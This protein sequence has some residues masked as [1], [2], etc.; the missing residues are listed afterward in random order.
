LI[1]ISLK[2]TQPIFDDHAQES[3]VV[4]IFTG[5][6]V[7]VGS[8]VGVAVGVGS[9]VAVGSPSAGTTGVGVASGVGV[10]A[11]GLDFTSLTP[12][13]KTKIA[14]NKMNKLPATNLDSFICHYYILYIVNIYK[15]CG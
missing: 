15:Y 4:G 7:G 2:S 5:V 3:R 10:D 8:A 6:A 13:L 14:I 11:G 1:A 12:T 9:G